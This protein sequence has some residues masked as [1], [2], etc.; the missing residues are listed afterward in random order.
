MVGT[1]AKTAGQVCKVPKILQGHIVCQSV[2]KMSLAKFPNFKDF[3]QNEYCGSQSFSGQKTALIVQALVSGI[4][5]SI[6][7]DAK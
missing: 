2:N 6:W 7:I 1:C 5:Q 4:Q 3:K